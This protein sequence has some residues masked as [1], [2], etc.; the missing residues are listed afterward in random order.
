[1]RKRPAIVTSLVGEG[2]QSD[3]LRELMQAL[4]GENAALHVTCTTEKASCAKSFLEWT[5]FREEKN[6]EKERVQKLTQCLAEELSARER[7]VAD[8][9][10]P[11]DCVASRRAD[12]A[13]QAIVCPCSGAEG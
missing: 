10:H 12:R 8:R 7:S 3:D 11:K 2:G 6:N 9:K 5:A 1:M 13:R 4:Q